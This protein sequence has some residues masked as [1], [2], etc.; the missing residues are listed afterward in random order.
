[1]NL[2]QAYKALYNHWREEFAQIELTELKEAIFKKYK[3]SVKK[4]NHLNLEKKDLVREKILE[5]YKNNF[6][7]LFNDLLLMREIKIINKALILDD[8]DFDKVIPP[9]KML[10]QNVV[11]GIKGYNKLKAL[12]L[13]DYNNQA[14]KVK[15]D[16]DQ[17]LM[18]TEELFEGID[19]ESSLLKEKES[20][21]QNDMNSK[22]DQEGITESASDLATD[23]VM[24]P[25]IERKS[26]ISYCMIRFVKK[27][28]AIVGVDLINY[29]P[30]KEQDVANL[31][32]LNAKILL[33]EKF[34]EKIEIDN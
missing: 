25:G 33:M 14:V 23:Q 28:P 1:M 20:S 2:E 9:E 11:S 27:T 15:K 13:F 22:G 30:F 29:G 32:E 34:A 26:E 7:Y 17:K 12:S 6:D 4:L 18:E 10:Y 8:L 5:S 3:K 31:P 24:T 21:E 16:Q 19:Q